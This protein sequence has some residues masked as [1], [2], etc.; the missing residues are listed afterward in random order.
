MN[1]SLKRTSGQEREKEDGELWYL[2]LVTLPSACTD[3]CLSHH[4]FS[5]PPTH[6]KSATRRYIQ[7]PESPS[8]YLFEWHVSCQRI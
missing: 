2:T 1:G 4:H 3:L 7:T 8:Y 6:Y 5:L